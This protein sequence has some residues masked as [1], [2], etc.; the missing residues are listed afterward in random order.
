MA[1]SSVMGHHP[2]HWG[3]QWSKRQKVGEGGIYFFFFFFFPDSLLKL[4]HIIFSCPRLEFTPLTPLVLRPSNSDCIILPAFIGLPLAEGRSWELSPPLIT[5]TNSSLKNISIYLYAHVCVCV[6]LLLA[7]SLENSNIIS[8][9]QIPGCL[10]RI[11]RRAELCFIPYEV[12]G[13]S[14]HCTSTV[15]KT[16][17][18]KVLLLFPIS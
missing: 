4:G 7:F 16:Q 2:I 17:S 3:P 11:D 1:L 14:G 5:W 15:S 8:N 9:T 12:T 18:K 13:R 10:F 6:Y